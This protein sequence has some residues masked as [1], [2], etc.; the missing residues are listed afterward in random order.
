MKAKKKEL[1][2]VISFA[3]LAILL[4]A[5]FLILKPKF[6]GDTSETSRIE[7]TFVFDRLTRDD[8]DSL[9]VVN[10]EGGFELYRIEKKLYFKG[11]EFV[12]YNDEMLAT[13]V[14]N[15]T[16]MIVTREVNDVEDY[17]LYGLDVEKDNPPYFEL[18]TVDGQYHKVYIGDPVQ[19]E[20]GYYVKYHNK[21]T[22][23]VVDG[24][25]GSSHLIKLNEY[26]MPF[27]SIQI[28]TP[29]DYVKI[30]D[31]YL[32]RR[33]NDEDEEMSRLFNIRA[34]TADEKPAS[35]DTLFPYIIAYPK[36]EYN[37]ST[38][39]FSTLQGQLAA[40]IGNKVVDYGIIP[41]TEEKDPEAYAEYMKKL[42]KWGLDKP[43]Y[44]ILYTYGDEDFLISFSKVNE[45]G[46]VYAYSIKMTTVVEIPLSK[47]PF[48][49]W[50]LKDYIDA[51]IF[52]HNI[53]T[54]DKITTTIDGKDYV[55][56]LFSD[57]K[58]IVNK[59][60]VDG[61]DYNV[62]AFRNYY[63]TM[64][65]MSVVDYSEAPEEGK[66]PILTYTVE[67]DMGKLKYEFYRIKS[68]RCFFTINGKGEFYTGYDLVERMINQTYQLEKGEILQKYD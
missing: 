36:T 46:N 61:K 41:T 62:D 28:S 3:A 32:S 42:E 65:R 19:N 54:V 30:N 57:D 63:L 34:K 12:M 5:T 1:I 24:S 51:Q 45:D 15:S 33:E 20:M 13:L 39:A 27:V 17:S 59:V 14:V 9:K 56:E 25:L 2:V 60:T 53:N 4:L 58:G 16:Y 47:V 38:D 7:R 37:A 35:G 26:L 49:D 22:V 50:G 68:R 48:L 6:E 44:E 21:D 18:K 11:A 10:S 23:Y 67:G 52:S 40:M 29:T 64:L 43:K 55:Y 8:I 66:E 31:F